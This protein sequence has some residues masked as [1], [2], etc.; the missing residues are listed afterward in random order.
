MDSSLKQ[1]IS[2]HFLLFEATISEVAIYIIS[3][4]RAFRISTPQSGIFFF[5]FS[6]LITNLVTFEV[7]TA[8]AMTSRDTE[9]WTSLVGK[10]TVPN[11]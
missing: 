3:M 6:F 8:Q 10:L 7:K 11:K 4:H 5:S 1:Y 2:F 9:P